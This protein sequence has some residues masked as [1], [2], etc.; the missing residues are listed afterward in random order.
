MTLQDYYIPR[1]I[2]I[3]DDEEHIL[4]MIR[5][6]MKTQGYGCLTALSGEEGFALA[7]K[8]IPDLII[9]DVMMPGMDGVETCRRVK[10]DPLTRRIPVLMLSAKSQGDDKIKGLQGGADDY[11]TKPF[12][13][14]ELFLRIKA[15][16]RQVDLLSSPKPGIYQVGS[17]LLDMDKYQLTIQGERVDLTMTEFRI[18]HLMMK[19]PGATVDRDEMIKEIFDMA[20]SEMG[21]T[22]DVHI[23]NIRKK[24]EF[25]HPAD[26]SIE[27][28][29]GRGFR[30][31]ETT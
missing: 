11:I 24:L 16:L 2:L 21:R 18:L 4:Q 12:S 31:I 6:N 8:H 17:L 29:R 25:Q 19:I 10:E 14:Q 15:A 26:C 30:L 28:I 9:L 22:L 13:L 23:R 3:I 5:M 7:R 27:T 20:P 1:K